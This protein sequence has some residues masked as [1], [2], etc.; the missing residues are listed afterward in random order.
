MCGAFARSLTALCRDFRALGRVPRYLWIIF[1]LKVL[2]SFAYFSM[3]LNMTLYFSDEFGMSDQR[4]GWLFGT[5]G[6]LISVYGLLGGCLI[7]AL[8][9]RCSLILG[10][11]ISAAGRLLFALTTTHAGLLLATLCLMPAGMALGIPVLTIAVKR[12]SCSANR[13]FLFGLFYSVMNVAA[14]V[15]GPVTDSL[16]SAFASGLVV[17]GRSLSSLRLVFCLGSLTT[18]SMVVI[19]ACG[20]KEV[21]VDD[22]TGELRAFTPGAG[23]SGDA[24][25][26]SSGTTPSY[27]RACCGSRDAVGNGPARTISA[28]A[29]QSAARVRALCQERRFRALLLFSL[30]LVGV[31]F[32]FRHLE[33]TLPKWMKREIGPDALYGTVYAINPFCIILLVPVVASLTKHRNVVSCVISGAFVSAASPFFLCLGAHYWNAVL[34]VL[35]LSVG[36]AVYS[37]K[38]YEYGMMLAPDGDEGVYTA[39]SS[40]P[41]FVL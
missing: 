23:G 20:I 32:I 2:E 11:L 7:D 13:T 14:L 22:R 40:V 36:E 3:S 30:L 39:L 9:V 29:R 12:Y 35:V 33:A 15:A 34:F 25:G 27:R 19:A 31:R 4:A 5:W 17:G 26:S 8:G 10:S 16:N 41:M 18:L 21:A 37:P 6:V 38:V 24:G 28:R 1:V